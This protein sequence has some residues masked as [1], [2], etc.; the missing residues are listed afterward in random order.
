MTSRT[1]HDFTLLLSFFS[2]FFQGNKSKTIPVVALDQVA[3]L[4][5]CDMEPDCQNMEH[6]QLVEVV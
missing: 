6:V 4:P 2:F 3:D 5:S 1:Y